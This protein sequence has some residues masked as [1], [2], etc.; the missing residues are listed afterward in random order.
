MKSFLKAILNNPIAD[1]F[2]SAAAWSVF[3]TFTSSV[4]MMLAMMA[5]ARTFS[6]PEYGQFVLTQST[7]MSATLFA[8][9]GL[10]MVATRYTA[11]LRRR[12]PERLSKILTLCKKGSL[13]GG[14]VIPLILMAGAL[15]FSNNVLQ[16]KE[17]VTAVLLASPSI[18]FVVH[19][20]YCKSVLIGL[21]AMKIV[22]VSTLLGA[23][24]GLPLLLTLATKFGLPG[25]AA[26]ISLLA[27][28]QCAISFVYYRKALSENALNDKHSGWSLETPLIR[29]FALPALIAAAVLGPAHWAA[30]TFLA[31]KPDGFAQVAKFG[32]ALQWFNVIT[33]LPVSAGK[34]ILPIL[35]DH[36]VGSDK[37]GSASILKY[38]VGANA[39]VAIPLAIF[40]FIFSDV[41][42]AQY[43]PEYVDDQAPF[44]IAVFTATLLACIG[45]IGTMMHAA[46]KMWLAA[47]TNV[48]WA[49]VY[50][51][52]A[53]FVFGNT[54]SEITTALLIAYVLHSVWTVVFALKYLK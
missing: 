8:G 15:P 54:A 7:M 43:G 14:L 18:F 33:F 27:L 9:L 46:S 40:L 35:T 3:G 13:T 52:L 51:G 45:P 25:A 21:E 12:D 20:T 34:V 10:N 31:S 48:A 29:Q 47:T 4:L 37:R 38:S 22:A 11:A 16:S 19:D 5:L 23:A 49:T 41:I 26:G 2:L 39:L 24:T 32:I 1:R 28:I 17:L 42:L 50:L 44:L 36:V 53:Y 6:T 30:Q